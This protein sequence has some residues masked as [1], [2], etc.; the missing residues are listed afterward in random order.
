M[1]DGGRLDG[2]LRE[3][4][5]QDYGRGNFLGTMMSHAPSL[6]APRSLPVAVIGL[7]LRA[8]LVHARRFPK[9][10]GAGSNPADLGAVL[11]APVAATAKIEDGGAASAL[12]LPQAPVLVV[13][14][15]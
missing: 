3:R 2:P 8:L 5:G 14:A 7:P 12:D 11:V 9:L 15:R 6:K 10:L 13:M 1:L 4:Q